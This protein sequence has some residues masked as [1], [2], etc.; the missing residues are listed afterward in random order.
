[1]H[2]FLKFRDRL[3]P[4][5]IAF[6]GSLLLSLIARMGSTLN[7]D[8]ILYVNTAQ[9]FLEEGFGAAK[10]VFN[11]PFLSIS[12]ALVSKI[13]GLGLENAGYLLNA[14]FMAGAC[15]L[16]VSCAQRRQPEIAW[17][18]CLMT[19][20]LPGLN[21][22]RNEL[23][24]E[25]GCWFFIMLAFWLALR[26]SEKPRWLTALAVQLALGAAALYRPEALAL[27]PAL[28]AW[29]VFAAPQGERCRRLL[30]LGGL[31]LA[32]GIAL[33][34]LHFSGNL[35]NRLASEL[36]RLNTARFDA[37][38]QILASALIDYARGQARTILLWGSIALVPIKIIQ[39]TGL[40]LI[41]LAF[42]FFSREAR[43]TAKRFP[44]FAWG[45]AAHLLVLCVFVIDLQFLAGRYV[46]LVLLFSAPFVATGFGL[47]TRRYPRWRWLMIGLAVLLALA[48]VISTGPGKQH[49]VEAGNW[50]ASN[51]S[52][53]SRVYIDS[54]RT[55]HHAGWQKTKLAER[56]DRPAIE[57]A[58]ADAQYDLFVLE[59]SR[60]DPP[61]EDWL[62]K[63]GL[64]ILKRFDHPNGDAVIIAVQKAVPETT[65]AVSN[66][67]DSSK[68]P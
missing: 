64:R 66:K 36:G 46:G 6:F 20:A 31:P 40:L 62:E 12:L 59:I 57:Q 35:S 52:A 61:V 65:P 32:G 49:F 58:T 53:P 38:A 5:G 19:L 22:Y 39:K 14:L 25:F 34:L 67:P 18:V 11:W 15:A 23:L 41:P 24:R 47:M 54:G 56:N 4:V 3:T 45:I 21:E 48:N 13:T 55:A 1:M 2:N 68:K 43:T 51:G 50:L 28:I 63:T 16:M 44:L 26:W 60:H 8:G 7:R 9:I 37:K 33:L 27:F 42:L 29:Q 17:S 10:A 30:M